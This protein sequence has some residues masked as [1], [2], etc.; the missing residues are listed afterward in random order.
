MTFGKKQIKSTITELKKNL[1]YIK[2]NIKYFKILYI[3]CIFKL[4]KKIE[5]VNVAVNR[6]YRFKGFKILKI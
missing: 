6:F 2:Y 4:Y 3:R 1:I 5:L